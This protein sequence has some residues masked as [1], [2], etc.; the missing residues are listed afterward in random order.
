[1]ELLQISHQGQVAIWALDH[2]VTNALS[3]QLVDE[4]AEGLQ[5][6]RNDPEARGLVLTSSNDKFFSIG[7]DIPKLYGLSREVFAAFYRAFNRVCLDLHSLPIPTVAAVTGHAIA[8]GCILA[9]CCDRRVCA[10]GRKLMGLNEI[11]LGVPVPY[12]ADRILRQIA[13]EETAVQMMTAGDFYPP[14]VLFQMGVVD[15]VLPLDEVRTGAAEEIASL[16][17]QPSDVWEGRKRERVEVVR[18]GVLPRLVEKERRFVE[19]WFSDDAR[20][21]LK[22]AMTKF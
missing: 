8:G 21:K 1:M 13:G 16:M 6:L 7:L 2:G 3:P 5:K 19:S 12:P 10:E 15:Q 11:K 14:E 20:H 18:A 22:E 4:L 9:L 17:G